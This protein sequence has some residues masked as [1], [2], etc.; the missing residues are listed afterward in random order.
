MNSKS[1]GRT[2]QQLAAERDEMSERIAELNRQQEEEKGPIVEQM[3]PLQAKLNSIYQEYCAKITPLSNQL[4]ELDAQVK[5]AE[6]E[7]EFAEGK[8]GIRLMYKMAKPNDRNSLAVTT[9]VQ[10]RKKMEKKG[11]TLFK[12]HHDYSR[13]SH[14]DTK[15][16][17]LVYMAFKGKK[18]VGYSWVRRPEKAYGSS[19]YSSSY[20]FDATVKFGRF[21]TER[22]MKAGKHLGGL[23]FRDWLKHLGDTPDDVIDNGPGIDLTSEE[24]GSTWANFSR[25]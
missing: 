23:K 10:G 6:Q 15:P 17:Q 24:H 7:W 8:E 13:F 9:D 14:S 12:V 4:R 22:G 11:I 2:A 3:K 5:E 21:P 1:L 19:Y 16:L 25:Y 20:G 18:C